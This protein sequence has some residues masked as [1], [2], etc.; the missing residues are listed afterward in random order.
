[1]YTWPKLIWMEF[2]KSLSTKDLRYTCLNLLKC[3]FDI[4]HCFVKL[5]VLAE[6][7]LITYI[8]VVGNKGKGV[9]KAWW[10]VKLALGCSG[11][12]VMGQHRYAY[13]FRLLYYDEYVMILT[14][15]NLWLS[16]VCKTYKPSKG[17][18]LLV[19]FVY[20]V[21]PRK[22]GLRKKKNLWLWQGLPRLEW[23]LKRI[24]KPQLTLF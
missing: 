21:F 3:I 2:K 16:L 6:P 13:D 23:I 12:A 17:N 18:N 22:W 10:D 5:F 7:W 19:T 11:G 4:L 8:R 9:D 15:F 14:C 20:E 1:M 24:F